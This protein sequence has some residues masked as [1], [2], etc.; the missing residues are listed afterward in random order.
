MSPHFSDKL[1]KAV[2]DWQAGS[3]GKTKK[4]KR[5]VEILGAS[6]VEDHL[7]QC[8]D[9]C[10]RRS[11]LAKEAVSNLYF[12]FKI[13]EETSSW[14]LRASVAEKFKGGPP[15]AQSGQ[16]HRPGVIFKHVPT[17]SE[18]VLNLE[19]LYSHE[20]FW[21]S[22]DHWTSQGVDLSSGIR[23]FRGSQHEV[24]LTVDAVPHNEIYAFGDDATL[25]FQ[26][27]GVGGLPMIGE[28]DPDPTVVEQN[29]S[30]FGL[31]PRRW[32]KG[33]G[34][35]RVYT[36]WIEKADRKMLAL[37]GPPPQVL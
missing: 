25:Q 37:L 8:A 20:A 16:P 34:V 35:W 33:E 10:F 27:D 22:V 29:F 1:L 14:T 3:V 21:P 32:V 18:V 11:V 23:K 19:N 30:Q 28:A 6:P 12:N 7:T 4:A 17:P 9:P 36:N 15:K 13:P 5:I 26:G 31:A 2:N 24:I